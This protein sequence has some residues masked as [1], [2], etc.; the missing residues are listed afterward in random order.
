[1]IEISCNVDLQDDAAVRQLVEEELVKF[2]SY[3]QNERGMQPM[4]AIEAVMVREYLHAR[5]RGLVDEKQT[6]QGQ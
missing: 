5:L 3:L 4:I 2:N 1:M 6:D